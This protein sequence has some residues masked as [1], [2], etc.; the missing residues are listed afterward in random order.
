MNRKGVDRIGDYEMSKINPEIDFE[1]FSIK[2]LETMHKAGLE[3]VE[4]HRVLAKTRDNIVKELLPKEKTFY[5]YDHCPPGDIFDYESHCQYYYHAHREGEHG[6]FHIFM[7]QKGM[8]GDCRPAK[9]SKPDYI[10]K[11]DEKVCHLVAISMDNIGIPTRLFTTNRWVTAE[12]WYSAKNV[13]A[14]VERF[15]IGHAKPSWVVNR[16]V[17]AMLILFH[18]QI[19]LI[20]E[21]RDVAVA[22]WK[23]QH[24][25]EDVFEDRNFMLPSLIKISVDDQNQALWEELEKRNSKPAKKASG[26]PVQ[27]LQ[28]L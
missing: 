6:H 3:V 21:Q 22:K 26:D 10:K 9:Q 2:K 20:L 14:M 12:S 17:T 24:P 7:R 23:K 16:W 25:G 18:P 27:S 1:K 28:S 4:C 13:L 5:Q 8:P 15:E 11:A 19:E